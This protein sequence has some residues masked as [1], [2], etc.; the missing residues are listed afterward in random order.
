M[1]ASD[2]S[3]C[4]GN[5]GSDRAYNYEAVAQTLLQ[6]QLE[7]RAY[8]VRQRFV[9]LARQIERGDGLDQSD[10]RELRKTLRHAQYLVDVIE[11]GVS[12]E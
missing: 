5:E 8:A 12:D 4:G 6:D 2:T 1:N 7:L 9:D 3:P 11:E 10:I